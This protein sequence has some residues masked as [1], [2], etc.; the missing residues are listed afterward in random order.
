MKRIASRLRSALAPENEDYVPPPRRAIEGPPS[1]QQVDL[2]GPSL[3]PIPAPLSTEQG[4]GREEFE[5]ARNRNEAVELK[6]AANVGGDVRESSES[7]EQS[8]V[9]SLSLVLHS[10]LGTL[11]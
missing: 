11:T 2:F 9:S 3:D 8:L 4:Q 7:G 6:K 5:R 10:K 1:L